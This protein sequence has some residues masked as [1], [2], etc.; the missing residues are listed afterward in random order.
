MNR[1][2]IWIPAVII[3]LIVLIPLFNNVACN[4]KNSQVPSNEKPTDTGEKPSGPFI[5]KLYFPQEAPK[6]GQTAELK[7]T[8]NV[9]QDSDNVS[10]VLDIPNGI[11]IV[12]G[13]T[14]KYFEKLKKGDTREWPLFIKP[15]RIGNYE[16]KSYIRF[17]L[18]ESDYRLREGSRS[19]YLMVNDSTAKWG[20]EPP[21]I[22][23]NPNTVPLTKVPEKAPSK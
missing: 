8:L 7:S 19:V 12:E 6:L 23:V 3:L 1:N 16:I 5:Y 17:N 14:T 13:S 9:V 10:L 18:V 15:D 11:Q 20:I 21:W 4:G 22:T 2:K